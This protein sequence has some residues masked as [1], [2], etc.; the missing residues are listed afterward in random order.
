[1]P[2]FDDLFAPNHKYGYFAHAQEYPFEA[3]NQHFSLVDAGWR[4]IVHSSHI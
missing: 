3:Q 1:M 4:P 2:S